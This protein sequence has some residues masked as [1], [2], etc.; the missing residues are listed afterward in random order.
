M[1]RTVAACAFA[2]SLVC[3]GQAF[4]QSFPAGASAVAVVGNVPASPAAITVGTTGTAINPTFTARHAVTPLP[5]VD[6]PNIDKIEPNGLTRLTMPSVNSANRA[7]GVVGQQGI[8]GVSPT[9]ATRGR[10]RGPVTQHPGVD[11]P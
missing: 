11:R 5:S 8:R 10:A 1:T 6:T 2:L 4:G 3:T 7:N 9:L